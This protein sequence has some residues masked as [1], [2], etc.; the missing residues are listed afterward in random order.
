MKILYFLAASLALVLPAGGCA[1][2]Q[3]VSD[4]ADGGVLPADTAAVSPSDT[5]AA[6]FD[7]AV[8]P[9]DSAAG[10][11]APEIG[12]NHTSA[13][14]PDGLYLAESY[15]VNT[16][17]TA[18]GLYPAEGIRIVEISSGAVL[19][20]SIGYYDT[21]FLW[22]ADSRYLA[23]TNM[24]RTEC[25]TVV[26]DL[27]DLSETAVPIPDEI[28][29]KMRSYRPD[30]YVKASEWLGVRRLLIAAQWIGND[31]MLY[32]GTFEFDIPT[33][34]VFNLVYEGGPYG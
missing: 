19:W 28:R 8:S 16:R 27:K 31:E 4:A 29:E 6:P 22:S 5:A 18:G 11:A 33:R 14:S 25:N 32:E 12:V 34:G 15:G 1:L 26:V 20:H 23:V 17:I 2:K 13:T 10:S 24:T 3:T 7:S 21:A 9:S 30:P